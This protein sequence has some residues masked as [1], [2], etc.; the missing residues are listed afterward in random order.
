MTGWRI[1]WVH[2]PSAVIEQ[3]LK[4]QQYTFVCAPQPLQWGALAALDI[5]MT[6]HIDE[7][8]QKRDRIY[9]GLKDHYNVVKPGGAF[10]I[11]PQVPGLA[12]H[13]P[14]GAPKPWQ[15]SEQFVATAIEKELLIIPG[16]IFS[17]H[18]DHFRISYA[19]EN[20][21]LD[22][23]IAVLQQLRSLALKRITAIL[24]VLSCNRGV[25]GKMPMILAKTDLQM[26]C[27][28]V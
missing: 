8:R 14:S 24:A 19:A 4:L 5:D 28:N 11:F 13:A 16:N 20:Q 3:L 21:T 17:R 25:M 7:Y 2:G 27:D 15:N 12:A 22:R 9:D 6:P 18:N 23:G 10:Y 26:H 1:G